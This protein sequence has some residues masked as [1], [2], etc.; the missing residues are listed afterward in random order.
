MLSLVGITLYIVFSE[1]GERMA[2]RKQTSKKVASI[3]SKVLR[4]DRY[5][6]NAKSAAASALA[7]TKSTKKK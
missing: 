1:G 4:D 5:S 2:N 7:Q 3:A 6:D